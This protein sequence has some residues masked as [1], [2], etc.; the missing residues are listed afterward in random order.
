[1]TSRLLRKLRITL[2]SMLPKT[3]LFSTGRGLS[4]RLRD[5]GLAGL[6]LVVFASSA[7]ADEFS[8]RAL[9]EPESALAPAKAATYPESVKPKLARAKKS[10][11]YGRGSSIPK[12]TVPAVSASRSRVLSDDAPIVDRFPV[13]EKAAQKPAVSES[14]AGTRGMLDRIRQVGHSSSE[15]EAGGIRQMSRN[16]ISN[17]TLPDDVDLETDVYN[18]RPIAIS[19]PMIYQAAAQEN[20]GDPIAAA[21]QSRLKTDIRSIQPTLSY[22]LKNIKSNQLPDD[23]DTKLDNGQYVARTTSPT[24][25]QWAP[26]NF[27]H[28]PLYF[29]DPSLER[30]GHT[31]HPLVQP[32]ASTGRFATQLVGLP[33]QMALHPVASR[34][35]AL[36]YY[37]PG[38]FAPKKHYQI[39]FNEEATLMEAAV[40]TGLI[41]IVP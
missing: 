22:A 5:A 29:E 9:V 8:G 38:E 40:I 27:Y 12:S 11:A 15:I 23:F 36:G 20:S 17:H 16:F 33:Y 34:Q 41:L 37:R 3:D 6:A 30:Y 7:G 26:T 2:W 25:L 28:Y 18:S 21:A 10:P 35:Y 14:F 31:Y 13:P 39:P 24:V 32:F 19:A 1:M 4:H